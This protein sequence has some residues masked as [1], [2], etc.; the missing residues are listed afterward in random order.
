MDVPGN[1]LDGV[2]CKK[3]TSM[4]ALVG[5]KKRRWPPKLHP[6]SVVKTARRLLSSGLDGIFSASTA[7]HP[8][9]VSWLRS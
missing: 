7:A 3:S 5:E 6:D 2:L 8:S 4:G 9:K 1:G